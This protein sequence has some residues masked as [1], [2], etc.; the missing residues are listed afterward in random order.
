M[1]LSGLP[2]SLF[3]AIDVE[4]RSANMELM[5]MFAARSRQTA[6]DI[7]VIYN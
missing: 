1:D 6:D 7:D 2:K 4:E 3:Q 5:V